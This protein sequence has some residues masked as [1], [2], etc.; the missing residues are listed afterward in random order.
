MTQAAVV[1]EHE[2]ETDLPDPQERKRARFIRARNKFF[3]LLDTSLF[4]LGMIGIIIEAYA[5]STAIFSLLI[6]VTLRSGTV[7]VRINAPQ[8]IVME[9]EIPVPPYATG[10]ATPSGAQ[11]G[12]YL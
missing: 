7:E 2:G 3:M 1:D 12:Q 11:P 10:A 4:L 8:P 6:L 9:Y 5:M